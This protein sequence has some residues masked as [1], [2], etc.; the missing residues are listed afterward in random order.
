MFLEVSLCDVGGTVLTWFILLNYFLLFCLS[1]S[2]RSSIHILLLSHPG[3]PGYDV[4]VLGIF[5]KTK[6]FL[7]K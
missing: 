6:K 5:L 7:G 1:V 4:S 2:F 3:H